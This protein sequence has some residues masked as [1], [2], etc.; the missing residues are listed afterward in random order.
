M[1]I[2]ATDLEVTVTKGSGPGGQHRNKTESA[3]T[4]RH[5]PTGISARCASDRSQ[6]KNRVDALRL[7][8][9]R[10]AERERGT[11]VDRIA[12]SRRGQVGSGMRGDKRRTIRQQDRTVH[13]HITGRRW[14][15]RDYE[16]GDW[17][18]S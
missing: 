14:S 15:Y 1:T 10:L 4:I 2:Q 7:V 12:S 9:T 13:D 6:H 11:A 8:V 18:A 17:G 3:V 5:L 16:R